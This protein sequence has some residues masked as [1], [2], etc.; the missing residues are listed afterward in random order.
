MKT[1]KID[2]N[3]LSYDAATHLVETRRSLRAIR[4]AQKK[5]SWTVWNLRESGRGCYASTSATVLR[6]LWPRELNVIRQRKIEAEKE[7]NSLAAEFESFSP[8]CQAAINN[9]ICLRKGKMR[10]PAEIY[11][12]FTGLPYAG[13]SPYG[14]RLGKF[15]VKNGIPAEKLQEILRRHVKNQKPW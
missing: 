14:P 8:A 11:E 2:G 3:E 4:I 5:S 7:K 1:V 13:P 9:A 15:L 6:P 10:V 12:I